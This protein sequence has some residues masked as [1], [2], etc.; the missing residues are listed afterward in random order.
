[1]FTLKTNVANITP[2]NFNSR[3]RPSILE[4]A[5]AV[6]LMLNSKP[7]ISTPGVGSTAKLTRHS[8]SIITAKNGWKCFKDEYIIVLKDGISSEEFRKH[9]L[10]A[11]E[12]HASHILERRSASTTGLMRNLECDDS[13]MYSGSFDPDT[14]KIISNSDQVREFLISFPRRSN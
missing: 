14:I 1:V 10:W 11:A 5:N 6:P 13:K 4:A 12:H 2:P 7:Y 3:P 9:C 8:K